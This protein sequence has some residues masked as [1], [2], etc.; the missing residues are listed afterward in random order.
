MNKELGKGGLG[1][2]QSVV[3]PKGRK[4]SIG[5]YIFHNRNAEYSII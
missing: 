3:G 2:L 4:E 5:Y 1:I